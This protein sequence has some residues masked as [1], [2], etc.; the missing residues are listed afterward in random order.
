M[1]F[2]MNANTQYMNRTEWKDKWYRLMFTARYNATQLSSNG[3]KQNQ[4]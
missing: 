4:S 1:D 2:V 3:A